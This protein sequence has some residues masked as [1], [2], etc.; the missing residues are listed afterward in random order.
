M[1]MHYLPRLSVLY[2]VIVAGTVFIPVVS[3]QTTSAPP[4]SKP[5]ARVHA[6]L[7]P[8]EL[9][10]KA[11]GGNQVGAAS[12]GRPVPRLYAPFLAKTYTVNPQ[13]HWEADDADAKVTFHLMTPDGQTVFET[14]ASGGKLDYP[15]SAPALKPGTTYRWTVIPGDEDP[16][17]EIPAPVSFIVVSG[18]ERAA[19][20]SEVASQKDSAAVANVYVNH[21]L[22]YDSIQAYSALIDRTPTDGSARSLRAQIYEQV[23]ATK[24]LATAD[25]AMVH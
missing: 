13:F 23:P 9:S 7:K 19:I 5:P 20:A 17:A 22:W 3:A 15:A 18:A 11:Q 4:A 12:R 2:G 16:F 10:P 1:T 14:V 24:P 8:F 21:S 25:W 6:D